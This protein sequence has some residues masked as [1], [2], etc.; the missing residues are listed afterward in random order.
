MKNRTWVAGTAHPAM[1]GWAVYSHAKTNKAVPPDGEVR[2]Y[3]ES[4]LGRVGI[5]ELY[6]GWTEEELDLGDRKLSLYH[7]KSDPGDPV[8][9]F[10]PGTSVYALLY[11]EYMYK[12][13]RQDFDVVGL[14][15]RGHG[16]SS[17]KRRVYT[18]GKL[19]EDAMAVSG[20]A[21]MTYGDRVAVSG[22]SQGGMTAFY[23]AAAEPRLKAAVYHNVIAP[24]EPDNERM[25]RR[26]DLFRPLIT[27]LQPAM[28]SPLDKLM[29]PVYLYLDLK[30]ETSRLIPDVGRSLK[31]DPLAVNAV[32]VSALHSLASTPPCKKVEGIENPVM[33]IHAD[34]DIIF[35]EDYLRRVYDRLTC[36][37]EFLYMPG[38]P[39]LVMTDYVDD[40]M[41]PISS[42]LKRVM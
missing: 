41:Q 12:L 33:V 13:S 24:D 23:C 2:A 5:M 20:S 42:W 18:L 7:F 30:A 32:S 27:L 38:A 21:I 19:A 8:M 37:K 4:L 14:D 31:E 9:I 10:V 26:P 35:P 25:T 39:H 1:A 3:I 17:G 36:E 40:I 15:P 6:G 22:S 28:D 16:R 34:R 11:T 29:T